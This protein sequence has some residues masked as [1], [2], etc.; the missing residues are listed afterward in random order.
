MHSDQKS[1]IP[2]A[3][4]VFGEYAVLFMGYNRMPRAVCRT[5]VS[6]CR[7]ERIWRGSREDLER[8]LDFTKVPG[9]MGDQ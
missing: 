2:L 8:I 1:F 9:P 6:A 4:D 5:I 3:Y 7:L